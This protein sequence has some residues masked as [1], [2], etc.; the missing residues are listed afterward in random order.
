LGYGYAYLNDRPNAVKYLTEYL[1]WCTN[2]CAE[3]RAFG[4]LAPKPTTLAHEPPADP[5]E[6]EDLLLRAKIQSET[7][8][9]VA[10]VLFRRQGETA[11]KQAPMPNTGEA[12]DALIPGGEVRGTLEYF[13]VIKNAADVI[14]RLGAAPGKP[15]VVHCRK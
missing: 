8:V 13:V 2:D 4:N 12:F 3:V 5:P 10:A 6:G 15:F 7:R 1:P 9:V 11:F 14:E